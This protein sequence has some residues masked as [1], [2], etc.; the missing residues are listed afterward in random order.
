MS[1][2]AAGEDGDVL[3]RGLLEHGKHGVIYSY[4]CTSAIGDTYTQRGMPQ[5]SQLKLTYSSGRMPFYIFFPRK[6]NILA[7]NI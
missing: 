3:L 5:Y 6:K 4:W 2:G 1:S 7:Y